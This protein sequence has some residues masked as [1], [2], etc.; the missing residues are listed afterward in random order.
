MQVGHQGEGAPS[1]GRTAGENDRPGLGNCSGASREDAVKLVQFLC[2]E[3]RSASQLRGVARAT[4]GGSFG[5]D[6][7]FLAACLSSAVSISAGS[8]RIVSRR[9]SAR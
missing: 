3:I 5:W 6:A 8:S 1:L 9:T 2:G 4:T 7:D